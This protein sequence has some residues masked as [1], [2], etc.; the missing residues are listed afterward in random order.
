MTTSRRRSPATTNCVRKGNDEDF[1]K[2]PEIIWPVDTPPFFC[3]TALVS[4]LLAASGGLC[5]R[6]P[7]AISSTRTTSP[8]KP[9]HVAGAAGGQYF[10]NDYPTICPGTNHGRCLTFGRIAGINAAGGDAERKSPI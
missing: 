10:S 7:H 4:T 2:R 5:A 1:G 3:R 6:I 8:S 9:L